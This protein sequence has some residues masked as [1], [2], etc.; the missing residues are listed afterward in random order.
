M[1]SA[2]TTRTQLIFCHPQIRAERLGGLKQLLFV[3]ATFRDNGST[4]EVVLHALANLT[5]SGAPKCP[6]LCLPFISQTA[7]DTIL[8]VDR[9]QWR[10]SALLQSWVQSSWW[11]R[12]FGYILTTSSSRRLVSRFAVFMHCVTAIRDAHRV[13]FS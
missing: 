11:W 10:A 12:C 13:D 8:L 3:A 9:S 6:V 7:A 4:V 5:T 2:V 1:I